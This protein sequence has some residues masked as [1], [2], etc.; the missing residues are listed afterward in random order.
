MVA[1]SGTGLVQRTCRSVCAHS[2][3][4]YSE[5]PNVQAEACQVV[6]KVGGTETMWSEAGKLLRPWE[7]P[8]QF[9]LC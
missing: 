1:G 7:R 2:H 5:E 6:F 3:S 8:K 9:K 4:L